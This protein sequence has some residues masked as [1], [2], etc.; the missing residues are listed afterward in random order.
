MSKN[1]TALIAL[2]LVIVGWVL[3]FPTTQVASSS[4]MLGFTL[5]PSE[6]P[7]SETPHVPQITPSTTPR[8]PTLPPPPT[9]PGVL[10]PVTGADNSVTA[11]GS[12]LVTAGLVVLALGMVCLGMSMRKKK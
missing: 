10:I 9:Q 6:I 2:C 3:L 1:Q 7:P 5:T 4:P 12:M 11:G 8:I